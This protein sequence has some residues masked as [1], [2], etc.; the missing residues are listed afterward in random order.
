MFQSRGQKQ[1]QAMVSVPILKNIPAGTHAP[2]GS[3][4]YDSD[5]GMMFVSN[6]SLWVSV[7]P[8]SDVEAPPVEIASRALPS[9][10]NFTGITV[11]N[12]LSIPTASLIANVPL[13]APGSIIFDTT[14]S[15]VYVASNAGW[16]PLN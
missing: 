11:F 8:Q 1:Q 4:A 6:G 16:L 3:L 10:S 5:S 9:D 12:R 2:K 15:R 14:A 7:S 13:Q